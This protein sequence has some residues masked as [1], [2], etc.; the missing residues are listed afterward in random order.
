MRKLIRRSTLSRGKI[1]KLG[2]T[3]S[4]HNP[5]QWLLRSSMALL[6]H[7]DQGKTKS[8]LKYLQIINREL[9]NERN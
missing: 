3:G 2:S 5:S 4:L 7:F 8:I 6:F 1:L 9:M